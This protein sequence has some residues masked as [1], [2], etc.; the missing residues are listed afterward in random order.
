MK[1][2]FSLLLV[3]VVFL[4]GC[5]QKQESATSTASEKSPE[6]R[7]KRDANGNVSVT[8]DPDTRKIS[9]LEVQDLTQAQLPQSIKSYGRVL[10]GGQLA[11]QFAELAAAIANSEVS[12]KEL[13]RLKTLVA[14]N[15]ASERALQTAEATATR[16]Q[17][18]VQALRLRFISVWGKM[19]T[20]RSDLPVLVQSLASLSNVLV[21]LN[22]SAGETLA[23]APSGARILPALS[24]NSTPVDAQFAGTAP[25]VDPQ[26]QGQGFFFL[27]SNSSAN[28]LPGAAVTGYITYS[29]ETQT[30]VLVPR[31]AIVRFNGMSW[32]YQQTSDTSFSRIEVHLLQPLAEGWFVRGPLKPGDKVVTLGAQLLLSEELKEQVSE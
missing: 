30:G 15:N 11:T 13:Q 20:E 12:Q 3:V 9:G 1:P 7:V 22:L 27:V 14:Q 25:T 31:S 18:Q 21:Q 23:S 16:D 32:V 10:D 19:I 2:A 5:S 28:L 29:G 6:P 26:L 17:S 24:T 8:L 4:G